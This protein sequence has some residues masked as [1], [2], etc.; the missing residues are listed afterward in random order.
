[1]PDIKISVA[2]LQQRVGLK[3]EVALVLRSKAGAGGIVECVTVGVRGL[4]LK[5]MG[6]ALLEARLER[7][8]VRN[9][10]RAKRG[11]GY[12]KDRIAVAGIA[13]AR[14]GPRAAATR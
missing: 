13:G 5:S 9:R 4:E 7:M 11:D 2:V 14:R 6:D 1:M 10:I 3:A 8:V 12:I